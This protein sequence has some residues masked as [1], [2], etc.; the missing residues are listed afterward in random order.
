ME[1]KAKPAETGDKYFSAF[2]GVAVP[3]F[4]AMVHLDFHNQDDKK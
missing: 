1:Q 3:I 2:S 4:E